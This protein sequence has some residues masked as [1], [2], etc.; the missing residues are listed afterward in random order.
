M[1]WQGFRS[2]HSDSAVDLLSCSAVMT[3]AE[4]HSDLIDGPHF[5]NNKTALRLRFNGLLYG[6]LS[7]GWT[8]HFNGFLISSYYALLDSMGGERS[9][10]TPPFYPFLSGLFGWICRLN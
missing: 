7:L 6:L 3:W 4:N 5:R 8:K 9:S 10:P 1:A 2:R